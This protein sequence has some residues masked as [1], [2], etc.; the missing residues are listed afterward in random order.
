[1]KQLWLVL[2]IFGLAMPVHAVERFIAGEHYQVVGDLAAPKPEKSRVVEFF[3]Y[4][5]PHCEHL[6][7]HLHKWLEG[8][9]NIEFS[10]VPAQWSAY[11]NDLAK[12]FLTLDKLGLVDK[13]SESVFKY[14]HKQRKPLRNKSQ[15]VTFADKTLGIPKADFEAA[16]ESAEVKQKLAEAGQMMR[17]Y[18][19]SGV[20]AI[21]V[22]ERYYVSVKLAGSE[23]ALFEVVDFLLQK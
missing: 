16:W 20:P 18:K 1:M 22:N 3:S 8:K 12:L 2:A 5:C 10:R 15:I 4:G 11:F 17:Q 23:A 13:H 7:P 6:E 14:I 21:L 19:V 9:N